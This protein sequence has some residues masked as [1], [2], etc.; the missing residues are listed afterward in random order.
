MSLGQELRTAE[1]DRHQPRTQ[2]HD[3]RRTLSGKCAERT[4]SGR[5][6]KAAVSGP[7]GRRK[8][9]RG[10]LRNE[11]YFALKAWRPTSN[12]RNLRAKAVSQARR[13]RHSQ[14]PDRRC[15][16]LQNTRRTN[17]TAHRRWLPSAPDLGD[18]YGVHFDS[19]VGCAC[20]I[21]TLANAVPCAH[22]FE[23][24]RAISGGD[25]PTG[26]FKRMSPPLEAAWASHYAGSGPN[27]RDEGAGFSGSHRPLRT[28]FPWISARARMV[29][30]VISSGPAAST[31]DA[32][33]DSLSYWPNI[34]SA[35]VAGVS[36]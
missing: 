2:N 28:W 36:R 23:S 33:V 13:C 24:R 11:P 3:D 10:I 22:R 26:R 19:S 16:V 5:R 25:R 14:R 8:G 18:Q 6:K 17:P 29:S 9:Q 32:D 12:M 34:V 27:A 35:P 7:G 1:I 30:M 15:R 20:R 31:D 4:Q 21:L